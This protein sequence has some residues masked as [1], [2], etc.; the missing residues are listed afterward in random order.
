MTK[1][2]RKLLILVVL[3]GGLGFATS[4]AARGNDAATAPCCDSCG[5]ICD[6]CEIDPRWC[7]LCAN[8]PFVCNP[9]C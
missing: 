2:L 6:K 1:L 9:G 7:N 3:L 4:H 5:D 8:C